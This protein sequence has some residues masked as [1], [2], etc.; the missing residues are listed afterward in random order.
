MKILGIETTCD[1]TAIAVVENGQ[2]ILF[3]TIASQAEK[4]AQWGGVFPEIAAREHIDAIL[5]MIAKATD[6][7]KQLDA[8]AVANGPGLIGSLLIGLTTAQA[9]AYSWKLPLIEVNHVDAHLYA[10]TMGKE[11][12]LFPALGVVVSGGHTF[13]C[14]MTAINAYT[15]IGQTVDDAIGEA[16]DKV[17][18]MLGYPY[19]GGPHIE[20]LAKKGHPDRYCF[21]AGKIKGR[22]LDFSFSGLKT[23]V[24]YTIK[25]KNGHKLSTDVIPEQDKKDVAAGF[26]KTAFSDVISKTLKAAQMF[27][28]QAIYLGGGVTNSSTFRDMFEKQKPCPLYWPPEGLSLDNAAMIAGLAFHLPLKHFSNVKVV[29]KVAFKSK[30]C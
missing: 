18:S 25:G 23:N 16:F 4:H 1:E 13:L 2:T 24:L 6:K 7:I 11:S 20:S 9:L 5:P 30:L 8:I 27:S 26:Q 29:P 10:A 15:V 19:P 21:K 17:A 14:K 28:C 12:P 3:H 22:P